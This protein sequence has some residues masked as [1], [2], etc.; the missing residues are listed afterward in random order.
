MTAYLSWAEH[1]LK[2]IQLPL[3]TK[4]LVSETERKQLGLATFICDVMQLAFVLQFVRHQSF[5]V[6]GLCNQ[7]P[8]Q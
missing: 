1:I 4:T 8:H 2:D 6:S 7:A 5:D 3:S